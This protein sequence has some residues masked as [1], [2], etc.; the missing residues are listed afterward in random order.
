MLVW[1]FAPA[2]FRRAF[3]HAVYR[4]EA[5]AFVL[6][7]RMED[8][9]RYW[10]MRSRDKNELIGAVR[11]T[12][13]LAASM[14][15][16]V[17]QNDALRAENSRLEALLGMPERPDFR[18][19]PARVAQRRRG[20]WWQ[21]IVLRRGEDAGIRRGCPV[22]DAYGVIGRVREVFYE[23]CIVELVSSPAFRVSATVVGAEP[24]SVTYQGAGALPFHEPT[25]KI[26]DLPADA[27]FP[28]NAE[29]AEVVTSGL[30]GIFP[31]GLRIGRLAGTTGD[32]S[33][34]IVNGAAVELPRRLASIEEAAVL[35]PVNPDILEATVPFKE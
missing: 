15:S 14:Q 16:S 33:G 24:Y 21:Q 6:S 5:P 11:N 23:F 31:A 35:V 10:E 29:T 1:W 19:V 9:G 12:S 27:D 3:Y 25:G 32:S 30:G 4:F 17:A 18:T 22:V 26:L 13:R 34:G 28:E 8:L 20:M 7:S 2:A